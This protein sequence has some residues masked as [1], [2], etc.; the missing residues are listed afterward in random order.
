LPAVAGFKIR[1]LV[2][3]EGYEAARVLVRVVN[4]VNLLLFVFAVIL[5]YL[6]S[7]TSL[8][9]RLTGAAAA[10]A[11]VPILPGITIGVETFLYLLPGIS[12]A[13]VAH[14]LMHAA[15][16]ALN[17][18]KVKG[19]GF[20]AVLGIIPIAFVEMDDSEL[21]RAPRA[22]RVAI[23]SAGVAGNMVIALAL[24]LVLALLPHS[25]VILEVEHG[26]PA[27]RAGLQ[28]GMILLSINGSEVPS[29]VEVRRLLEN[30]TSAVFTVTYGG[31]T[32]TITVY[33][34][35]APRYGIAVAEVPTPF[36]SS[37]G[38]ETG[39]RIAVIL[40]F[41]RDVNAAV[42]LIN[43]APIFITDGARLLAEVLS[44]RAAL[45]LSVISLILL[46]SALAL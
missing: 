9:L 2:K 15:T 34:G 13:I 10:G 27:Y 38:V 30:S 5:F 29:P 40:R 26:S 28:P 32:F 39:F 46:L 35:D 21:A 7:G 6:I 45:A 37:F 33:K 14:E 41:V 22:S 18:V 20:A 4:S 12:V 1:K 3:G 16:A 24:A 19:F 36:L 44:V 43:A 17:R 42:A 23:Y 11:F 8:V 31:E 25:L